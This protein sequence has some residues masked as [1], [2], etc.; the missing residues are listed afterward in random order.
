[1]QLTHFHTLRTAVQQNASPSRGE[2]LDALES[3]L[4]D[5]LGACG[6]FDTVEV[7]HTDDVD[8][9][10]VGLCEYRTSLTE[11]QVASALESLWTEDIAY[12]FW[13]A[14][15]VRVADGFVELEAASRESLDGRYVT[16]H[17][18]AQR[19]LVPSQRVASD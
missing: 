12:P 8:Q 5:Q 1:M 7:E 11:D 15:T 3:A 6:L 14:N 13:Q 9:L 17:V 19:S 18:V 2:A 4:C 10:V 16:V